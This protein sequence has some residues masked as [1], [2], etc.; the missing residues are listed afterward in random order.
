MK[1]FKMALLVGIMVI[2]C[3]GAGT[4]ETQTANTLLFTEYR[5]S[6]DNSEELITAESADSESVEQEQSRNTKAIPM[7]HKSST[8]TYMDYRKITDR[9]SPQWKLIHSDEIFVNQKGYLQ[10]S[11]GY[12][13]VAM[14]SYFEDI[15][16]RYIIKLSTGEEI[17]VIKVERKDD[18]HT[19]KSNFIGSDNYDIIE[20]VIDTKTAHMRS[21][22]YPNG[23]IYSG[24][25]NNCSEFSGIIESI[26]KVL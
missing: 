15:G 17:K 3:T 18:R 1:Y 14:G 20:F 12:I 13:G 5:N 8:K 4:V 11:D 16:N 25:F 21:N 7:L 22:I 24:N 2:G 10:T 26:E 19:D 9:S 23:Y 6:F